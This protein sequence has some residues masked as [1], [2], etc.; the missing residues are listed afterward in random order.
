M[1]LRNGW[2]SALWRHELTEKPVAKTFLG[3]T[4]QILTPSGLV[5][6]THIDQAGN[7]LTFINENGSPS[8]ATLNANRRPAENERRFM[9]RFTTGCDATQ[10]EKRKL[11]AERRVKAHLVASGVSRI[12]F[13]SWIAV[14][15][16]PAH[17]GCY[18]LNGR[19][20]ASRFCR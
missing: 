12:I 5:R 6:A 19:S 11:S 3:G 20:G 15:S 10:E 17:A 13:S 1:F 14:R 16:D 4:W 2:Y 8:A 7:Q 18:W 9:S